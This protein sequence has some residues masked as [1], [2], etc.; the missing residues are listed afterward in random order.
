MGDFRQDRGKRFDGGHGGGF[1]GRD[2]G[3]PNFQRKSWGG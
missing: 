3:R 1:G 2:G